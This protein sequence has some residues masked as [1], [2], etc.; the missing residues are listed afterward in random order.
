M[1][2]CWS[3]NTSQPKGLIEGVNNFIKTNNIYFKKMYLTAFSNHLFCSVRNFNKY[4]Q[5]IFL[6]ETCIHT[7]MF[8]NRIPKFMLVPSG[9][10]RV[11]LRMSTD[12]SSSSFRIILPML[13]CICITNIT[14][15]IIKLH[16]ALP[17]TPPYPS[18]TYRNVMAIKRKTLNYKKYSWFIQ[19]KLQ[20]VNDFNLTRVY[21]C[22]T[23]MLLS[24]ESILQ[25]ISFM[26]IASSH[27]YDWSWVFWYRFLYIL[28]NK[29]FK[30]GTVFIAICVFWTFLV[31]FVGLNYE[32]SQHCKVPWY[33]L[34]SWWFSVYS[35]VR[36]LWYG[37]AH[38]W[39]IFVG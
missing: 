38:H 21:W 2:V 25:Y 29:V 27:L 32:L 20:T 17:C 39:P 4:Q 11:F 34:V 15:M 33:Y 5:Q 35:I 10:E 30:I 12:F 37:V 24:G 3:C 16:L 6:N 13:D 7:H 26:W 9:S 19:D 28:I 22:G 8:K 14:V 23:V 36:C 1:T 31:H 18:S